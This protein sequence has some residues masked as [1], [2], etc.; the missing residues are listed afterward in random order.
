MLQLC[1]C[2]FLACRA[3]TFITP[4]PCWME[5]SSWFV[6]VLQH[7]LCLHLRALFEFWLCRGSTAH[8]G[9]QGLFQQEEERGS[10]SS[11][12][13]CRAL[14]RGRHGCSR[15]RRKSP[16]LR[17]VQGG[18]S[19]SEKQSLSPAHGQRSASICCHGNRVSHLQSCHLVQVLIC[20]PC[21][22]SDRHQRGTYPPVT[23]LGGG[24]VLSANRSIRH[25]L[26]D[27]GAPPI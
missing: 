20:E 25:Q 15:A 2:L 22:G 11:A 10:Q 1:P 19:S 18:T 23:L 24:R 8:F 17:A 5:G 27:T 4:L 6:P 13:G 9:A 26:R 21:V 3:C 12:H 16:Q 7:P 14:A